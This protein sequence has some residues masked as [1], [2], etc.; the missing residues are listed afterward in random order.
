MAGTRRII[1][2]EELSDFQRWQFR[3]LLGEQEIP[4]ATQTEAEIEVAPVTELPAEPAAPEFVESEP[5]AMLEPEPLEEALPYPT[6]EEIEAIERQAHEEGYLAGLEAGR[7]QAAAELI[8]LRALLAGMDE[9]A[10]SAES[11]LAADV[12]DLALVIARQLVRQEIRADR[13]LVLN[14][15]REAIAGLPPVKGPARMQL[16]PDDLAVV[17]PLLAAELHDDAWRFIADA[18]L[19]SGECRIETAASALDLTLAGRWQ[20]VLRVLGRESRPELDWAAGRDESDEP[21]PA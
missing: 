1:P 10:R 21:D 15:I 13:N 20:G 3:T 16:N 17:G 14:V 19:E 5:E 2:R 11:S 7:Q 8:A 4:P 6:A 9:V 12:L 18:A